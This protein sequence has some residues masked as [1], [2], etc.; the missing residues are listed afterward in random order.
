MRLERKSPDKPGAWWCWMKGMEMP[1]TR[2]LVDPSVGNDTIFWS[3]YTHFAGP[4]PQPDLPEPATVELRGTMT[5]IVYPDLGPFEVR[6]GGFHCSFWTE[7]EPSASFMG[8]KLKI[9]LE[10]LD[11]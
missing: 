10:R 7:N 9:T 6:E 1:V 11:E 5:R 8:A 3:G 2:W 4:I